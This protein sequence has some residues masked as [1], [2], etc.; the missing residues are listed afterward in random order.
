MID[1]HSWELVYIVCEKQQKKHKALDK[2]LV[3]GPF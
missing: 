3:D 2:H 1:D